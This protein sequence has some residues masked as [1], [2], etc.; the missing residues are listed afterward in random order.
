[1]RFLYLNIGKVYY[2]FDTQN[3]LIR[4]IQIFYFTLREN[5]TLFAIDY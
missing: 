5:G 2:F 4:I 1:M 3:T